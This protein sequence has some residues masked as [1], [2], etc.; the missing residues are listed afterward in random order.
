MYQ[1]FHGAFNT[2]VPMITEKRPDVCH[3]WDMYTSHCKA[4]PEW[5]ITANGAL[6]LSLQK[7]PQE[8]PTKRDTITFKCQYQPSQHP[9]CVIK[10]VSTL[11]TS[12][13][14]TVLHVGKPLSALTRY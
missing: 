11:P 9:V 14:C 3:K 6:R 1:S 4:N 2:N 7:E 8:L 12:C 5:M 13:M 10:P